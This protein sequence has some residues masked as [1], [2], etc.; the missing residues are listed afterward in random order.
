MI[1]LSNVPAIHPEIR[2]DAPF[3]L[4]S[5]GCSDVFGLNA[6]YRLGS[7]PSA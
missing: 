1:G 3:D 5:L 6:W 4:L 2:P 7:S